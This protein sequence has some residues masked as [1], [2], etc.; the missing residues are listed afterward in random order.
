MSDERRRNTRRAAKVGILFDVGK[1]VEEGKIRD[2]SRK[3]LS[4][5]AR[6]DIAPGT[7]LPFT[8][9]MASSPVCGI[10]ECCWKERA[11]DGLYRYGG[12]I[13]WMDGVDAMLFRHSLKADHA[14]ASAL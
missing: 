14:S 8:L 13:I 3:G 5:E 6:A 12:R 1:S 2:L 11:V 7:R 9:K 10:F 4:V